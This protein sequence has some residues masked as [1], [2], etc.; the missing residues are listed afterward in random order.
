MKTKTWNITSISWLCLFGL[1]FQF[2]L[3]PQMCLLSSFRRQARPFHLFARLR[4]GFF[5]R[6]CNFKSKILIQCFVSMCI[7]QLTTI[8]RW[9]PL[10]SPARGLDKLIAEPVHDA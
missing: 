5:L 3:A 4:Q 8:R 9:K 7:V 6:G 10:N 2:G 1:I